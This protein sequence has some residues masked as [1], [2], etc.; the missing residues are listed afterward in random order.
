M[1]TAAQLLA[2]LSAEAE[3]IA[4][5]IEKRQTSLR[6]KVS[7]AERDLFL[8]LV[9]DVFMRL[10]LSQGTIV[11]NTQNLLLLFRIDAVFNAWHTEVMDPL[12]SGFV[13]DLLSISQLTGAYYGDMAAAKVIEDIATSNTL[14]RASLGIDEA[15]RMRKGGILYDISLVPAVRQEAKMLFLQAVQKTDATLKDLQ[16]TVKDF[17]RGK[18][19]QPGAINANFSGRASGYAY[20]LFN[21]VAEVKNEQFR[22][23]LNLQWFIYVGDIIKDSRAFCVKKAGKVFAVPEADNEW[24]KDKD[25]IGRGTGIPYTPRIDRGRWNCR[26]RIRYISEEMALQLDPDKVAAMK[27]KYSELN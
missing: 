27:A 21:R 2:R 1:P 20:D 19:G 11:N 16:T 25:L 24:P 26:H 4:A 12:M 9:E 5:A 18:A 3:D 15:G 6:S 8:R 7:A 17:I 23:N 22:E 13:A 14:F 10:E